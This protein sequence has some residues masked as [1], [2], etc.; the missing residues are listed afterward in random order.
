MENDK[1]HN[2]KKPI[3]QI[4]VVFLL[5]LTGRLIFLAWRGPSFSPDSTEYLTLAHNIVAHGAFSLDPSAPFI[6]SLRRAPAYPALLAIFDLLGLASP[7]LIASFQAVLDASVAAMVLILARLIIPLR[8][9]MAAAVVYAVHPG[10]IYFAS[11]ILSECLFGFLQMSALT[12]AVPGLNR[13]RTALVV[14]GGL[15]FGLAILA[16]PIALPLPFIFVAVMLLRREYRCYLRRGVIFLLASFLVVAPWTARCTYLAHHL[17]LVQGYSSINFWAPTLWYMDQRDQAAI[18]THQSETFKLQQ[19]RGG[20]YTPEQVVE[21]D[22]LLFNEALQN[23]RANPR[24]YLK[25]R[26]RA[27]PYLAISS[28]DSFANTKQSFGELWAGR[29]LPRLSLKIFLLLAFSVAPL[30][31]GFVGALL[32]RRNLTAALCATVWFYTLIVHLPLWIENRFWIP[33]AP[34]LLVNAAMGA[35]LLC[36]RFAVKHSSENEMTPGQ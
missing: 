19:A 35:W 13:K 10:A 14:L 1:L 15:L 22:R 11:G 21:D 8:W 24:E 27:Y 34:F 18:W 2:G 9:A 29:D 36:N 17:V 20:P 28:F 33:V 6:A 31:L 7:V 26:A 23:I 30:I 32:T 4:L 12:L 5:A 25:S 16:R 3:V